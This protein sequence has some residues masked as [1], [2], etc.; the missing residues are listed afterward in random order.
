MESHFLQKK[1]EMGALMAQSVRAGSPPDE[2]VR[3]YVIS[4]LAFINA[5]NYLLSHTLS[6]AVH[7]AQRGLT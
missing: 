6:R 3:G 1:E 5:G 4:V 7:S 2:G